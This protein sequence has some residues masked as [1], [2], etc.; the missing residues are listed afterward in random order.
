VTVIVTVTGSPE[1]QN[2]IRQ[3]RAPSGDVWFFSPHPAETLR[4][5][6]RYA[7]SYQAYERGGA[8]YLREKGQTFV[9]AAPTGRASMSTSSWV[10]TNRA[11]DLDSVA[12]AL[13]LG[14]A[15]GER[16]QWTACAGDTFVDGV[17]GAF[18]LMPD[19]RVLTWRIRVADHAAL[20]WGIL[21]PDRV[22]GCDAYRIAA[23]A[24]P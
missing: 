24:R 11:G 22:T 15:L 4:N 5:P 17:V 10:W 16:A 3:R 14:A 19:M 8:L 21:D 2:P 18:V 13:D 20:G 1:R 6:L 23:E 7:A 9:F 12:N